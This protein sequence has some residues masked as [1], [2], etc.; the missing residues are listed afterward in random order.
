METEVLDEL[1]NADRIAIK[2]MLLMIQ[3]LQVLR[4]R[5]IEDEEKF[6]K[7]RYLLEAGE[8]VGDDLT[9]MAFITVL[10]EALDE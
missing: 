1:G 7:F 10:K 4:K 9:P 6:H 2:R 5:A 3:E 8:L